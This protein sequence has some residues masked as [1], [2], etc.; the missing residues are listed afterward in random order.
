MKT[1]NRINMSAISPHIQNWEM[2]NWKKIKEYV[3]KTSP[4]DFS[5]EQLG[6]K[7]K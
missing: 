6:T 7:A 4:T 3:K 5:D 1:I 2:I